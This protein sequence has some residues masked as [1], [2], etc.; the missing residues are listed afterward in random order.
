MAVPSDTI[1]SYTHTGVLRE[2]LEDIIYNISPTEVPCQAN[3]SRGRATATYHE[4]NIDTLHAAASNKHLSGDDSAN[5]ARDPTVRVGNYTQISK[6]T[7]GV[8]GTQESV[9]K[10][11]MRSAMAYEVVK[12]GLEIRNS[13]T[14][15]DSTR[16]PVTPV[17]ISP[18]TV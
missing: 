8:S 18:T 5:D 11:G 1:T 12:M 13:V 15:L 7:A 14:R 16:R 4:W 9:D 6:R 3:F 2:D 17:T 10:A